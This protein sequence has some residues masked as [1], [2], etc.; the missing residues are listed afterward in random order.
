MPLPART[1][2][3]E[4][5]GALSNAS[6]GLPL[7]ARPFLKWAGSKQQ[8]RAAFAPL[9]P[10]PDKKAGYHEP[11]LGSGAVFFDVRDRFSRRRCTLSDGNPDLIA[12]FTAVRDEVERVIEALLAHRER[13]CEKHF[14]ATRAIPLEQ[15]EALSPVE[16]GARLIYLNKTC[17]NG[18]YRV[19]SR[20]LFNVPMGSYTRP[21]IVDPDALRL[22]SAA[23]QGVRL[24]VAPFA[25]VLTRARAGDVVYFDPPYVP[26]NETAYFTSY[27]K[28]AFG[29]GEQQALATVYRT[30]DARGCKLMLSNSDTP[31]VRKLYAGFHQH[32]VMARRNINSRGD[33]RGHVAELVV[34]NYVPGCVLD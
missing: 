26:L 6:K 5:T 31:L 27:M 11:F 25:S 8:L 21:S 28:T 9:Y 16:R 32:Q 33:R 17:F 4:A 14:Y 12:A 2:P 24:T 30:L 1:R 20:G 23:L 7:P 22:A 29:E 13:H 18:L 34:C 3:N 10:A 15:L 19:N